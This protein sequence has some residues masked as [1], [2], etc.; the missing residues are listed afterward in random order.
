MRS[1]KIDLFFKSLQKLSA[2]KLPAEGGEDFK[3]MRW[4]AASFFKS[5]LVFGLIAAPVTII[6]P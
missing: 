5:R 6:F 2:Q 3:S 4:S 1:G